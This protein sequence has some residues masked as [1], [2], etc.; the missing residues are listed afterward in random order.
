LFIAGAA[1]GI[2]GLRDG[3]AS[4]RDQDRFGQFWPII[5]EAWSHVAGES[6]GS[7]DDRGKEGSAHVWLADLGEP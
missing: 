4:A 3:F 6:Q 5:H 1:A 7:N 2:G